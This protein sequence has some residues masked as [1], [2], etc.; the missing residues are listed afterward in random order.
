MK[1]RATA[2]SGEHTRPACWFWRPAKTNFQTRDRTCDVQRE[3]DTAGSPS[4]R[5]AATN[6]RDA[7]AP[8]KPRTTRK[9]RPHA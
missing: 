5:D 3:S 9:L 4:R 7:R 1:T 2:I 8:R 6:T